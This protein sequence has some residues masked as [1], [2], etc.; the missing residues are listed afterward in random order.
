MGP[1]TS[2]CKRLENILQGR[3]K[4]TSRI[5]KVPVKLL[6]AVEPSKLSADLMAIDESGLLSDVD[7]TD[8]LVV[9]TS[10]FP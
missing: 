6:D 10:N 3:W 1:I 8:S 4:I 7:A 5:R 9:N 2:S